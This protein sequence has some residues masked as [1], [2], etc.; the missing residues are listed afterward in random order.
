MRRTLL[1]FPI[2]CSLFLAGCGTCSD[3]L[4]GSV[5]PDGP[6]FYRGVRSDL[7]QG[8]AVATADNPRSALADTLMI[9]VGCIAMGCARLPLSQPLPK[10]DLPQSNQ[11]ATSPVSVS[12]KLDE[13]PSR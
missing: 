7:E 10:Y 3:A 1:A 13:A 6:Y 2:L 11:S 8:S 9:P 12:V 4:F 5:G